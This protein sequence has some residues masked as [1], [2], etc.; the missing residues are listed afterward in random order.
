MAETLLRPHHL[1]H[2]LTTIKCRNFINRRTLPYDPQA[3]P[4]SSL[5]PG[6]KLDHS[7]SESKLHWTIPL[8]LSLSLSPRWLP[9]LLLQYSGRGLTVSVFSS[10]STVW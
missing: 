4:V 8:S 6:E 3:S 9:A 5:R 7:I 2:R 1:S 10:P